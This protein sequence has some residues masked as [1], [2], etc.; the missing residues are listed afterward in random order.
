[1]AHIAKNCPAKREEYKKRNKRNH[2]HTVEDEE[3]PTKMIKEHIKDYV[4]ISSLSGSVTPSEDTWLI[5]SGASNHMT[6]Q[7][8]ILS[9][10]TEKNFPQKVILGDDYQYPIKGVGES[11]YNLD[12]G[13]PMKMKDVLYVPGLTKN[14]LSISA[15]VKKGFRIAFIDGEVLM[16]PKG[17][18]IEEAIVIGKEEGGLYK[19][20]GHSEAALTHSIENPCELWHR[21]LAHINS[22]ALPYVSKA[23]TGLPE[24]KV[25]HEGVCNG[26]A[27]GKNIKN[28]FPK[29]DS[30]AGVLEL[31]HSDVCGPMPSTSISGYVY[32]VSFIDDYSRKTWIYFLKS[33]DEV[34]GKFK[35][36]KTLIENLSERKSKI[37]RSDNG[38]EYT[39]KEF[40]NFC[41]DVGI[42][43]ELTTPYNPQQNGVAKRKNRTIIEVVK[44]MIHDQDLPMNLWAEAARTTVYVQNR[45]FHSA[46][47]FKTPEE[48]FSRKRPKVSHLKIFG[49]PVFVHIPKEKRTKL[50][51]SGKKG[52]FVGYCEV[53]KAFRIYI[54]GYHH[55]EISRDVTFDEDPALKKSRR[56][57]L[58]EVYE[59]EPVAPRVAEPVR[60]VITSPDEEILE[61]HDIIESQEPPLMTISQKKKP[62]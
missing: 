28:P 33:K 35:E 12:S 48:M 15:L 39:S 41:K 34:F 53:S 44:T 52:I 25:D 61:D 20:K 62:A 49:Y 2:A 22:K 30:K 46:L 27:Q 14:L 59:E 26:C 9:C 16:W 29:R 37:L 50:D 42:K 36:F 1:M 60:E 21:R 6:G 43:R 56:C 45:L 4:L 10:L 51:P 7:R 55:I 5:D 58:E 17:K 47:G 40:V 31:I 13:T 3:P 11:N 24:F 38:G 57:Q 19:L 23:V 54:P 32:Y 8:N 18:T